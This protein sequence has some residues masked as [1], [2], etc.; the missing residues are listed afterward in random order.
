MSVSAAKNTSSRIP[1]AA[2]LSSKPK[3]SHKPSPFIA[4]E[5]IYP[6]VF[7]N[8]LSKSRHLTAKND[9]KAGTVILAEKSP[10]FIHKSN[11]AAILCHECLKPVPT[12]EA[13]R[14][15]L[16]K[17]GN[18]IKDETETYRLAIHSCS[19]CEFAVYCSPECSAAHSKIHNLECSAL[20]KLVALYPEYSPELDSLRFLLRIHAKSLLKDLPAFEPG[21]KTETPFSFISNIPSH[22]ETFEKSVLEATTAEIKKLVNIVPELN[23]SKAISNMITHSCRYLSNFT[24]FYDFTYRGSFDA[25]GLFP[26]IAMNVRHSCFPN[27][28]ITGDQGGVVTIRALYDI[29]KGTEISCSQ[30]EL[31]QP[32]EHRRR[33]LLLNRHIWCKCRRCSIPLSKSVDQYMDG[34]VCSKCHSGLMIFEETKEVDDISE[35]MKN[36]NLLDD[37]IQGKFAQCSM[38]SHKITVSDLVEILKQAI[39]KFNHAFYEYRSHNISQARTLF[40]EYIRDFGN[41][42]VLHAYNS[43]IVNSLVPLMHCCRAMN[44]LPSAIKYCKTAID[45]M[46]SSDALPPSYPDITELRITLAEIILE[47]AQSK[48]INKVQ[49]QASKGL[50]R[51]QYIDAK[52]YLDIALSEREISC[53]KQSRKYLQT[54]NYIDVCK[55]YTNDI[56]RST[57]NSANPASKNTKKSTNNK[58][59][60]NIID[61]INKK[62]AQ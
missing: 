23:N 59:P 43:Y 36:A 53:G 10:A 60:Q 15:K 19:D 2:S 58:L 47:Y 61:S 6:I 39:Q 52:K 49:S 35:L 11:V 46:V 42:R 1:P 25:I 5:A 24:Q 41:N 14:P 4:A 56:D 3:R 37:E 16:D 55:R 50:I 9:I 48:S 27:A 29:P 54:L 26:M 30:T 21:A 13:T 12:K 40:E 18:P 34:I 44:D 51:K 57:K 62:S 32:R 31:Y 28:T 22:R 7:K 45:Y 8:S 20:K 38:C 17:E 33:D